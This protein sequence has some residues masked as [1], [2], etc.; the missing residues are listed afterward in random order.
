M[1]EG[2]L[3]ERERK[4]KA[5]GAHLHRIGSFL[6]LVPNLLLGREP[7]EIGTLV[8]VFLVFLEIADDADPRFVAGALRLE[9]DAIAQATFERAH[10]SPDDCLRML[11][12]GYSP[13]LVLPSSL[14]LLFLVRHVLCVDPFPWV[15]FQSKFV[16]RVVPCNAARKILSRSFDVGSSLG[17]IHARHFM[18]HVGKLWV[19]VLNITISKNIPVSGRRD[20]AIT[21]RHQ[22]ATR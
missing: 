7:H 16:V 14:V 11:S 20:N 3:V 9:E 2:K 19:D 6:L 4:K 1:L 17:F 10:P 8:L 21:R 22:S 5:G 18:R 12:F 13:S 15:V